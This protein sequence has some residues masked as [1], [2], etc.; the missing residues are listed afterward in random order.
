MSKTGMSVSCNRYSCDHSVRDMLGML[1]QRLLN[2]DPLPVPYTL[3]FA[4]VLL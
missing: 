2:D 3:P 4:Y 1:P